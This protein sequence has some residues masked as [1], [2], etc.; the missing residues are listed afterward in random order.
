[1]SK[2]IFRIQAA[3]G[4]GP[5]KPGFSLQWAETKTDYQYAMLKPFH[6]DFRGLDLQFRNGF[7]FGCGCESLKQLRLWFTQGEYEK[8]QSFGYRCVSLEPDGILARSQVQCLFQ[9]NIPLSSNVHP[10]NLYPNK[11]TKLVHE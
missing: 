3:D 6:E 5:W 9:R 7:H 10:V 11:A 8:L 1:M 2:W 4:R